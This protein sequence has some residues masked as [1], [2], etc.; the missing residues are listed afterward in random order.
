MNEDNDNVPSS[1]PNRETSSGGETSNGSAGGTSNGFT[2]AVGHTHQGDA[3]SSPYPISRLAGA[4]D[5]VD[6]AKQISDAD[7]MIGIVASAELN[8]IADQI[9]ALQER[10]R[11]ILNDAKESLDIHQARASFVK[12]PGH[13]YHLYLR[14]NSSGV[15]ERSLSMISPE[16]WGGASTGTFL[17]SYRLELDQSWTRVDQGDARAR[18]TVKASQLLRR[19]LGTGE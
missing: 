12:R 8:L 16:E 13:V 19:T 7:K 14:K 5:L 10:A 9:R 6:I 2:R 17:G 3:R 15:E 4:V 11:T 1:F 18:E